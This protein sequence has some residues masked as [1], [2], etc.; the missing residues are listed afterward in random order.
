MTKFPF[1]DE[2]NKLL[3]NDD[4]FLQHMIENPN[5]SLEYMQDRVETARGAISNILY[6]RPNVF[7]YDDI[8]SF[9]ADIANTLRDATF[10]SLTYSD[11]MQYFGKFPGSA[12]YRI[13]KTFEKI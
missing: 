5:Y 10:V 7:I 4:A 9:I 2:C 13:S 12:I 8:I 1:L 11:F 3:E 6:G